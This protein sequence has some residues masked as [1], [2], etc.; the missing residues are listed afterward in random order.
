MIL[1]E[2]GKASLVIFSVSSFQF[3][4]VVD[5][6]QGYVHQSGFRFTVFDVDSC[7]LVYQRQGVLRLV[8]FPPRW[9]RALR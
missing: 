6:G 1:A 9:A 5:S 8:I 7:L 3:L 4:L 2:S